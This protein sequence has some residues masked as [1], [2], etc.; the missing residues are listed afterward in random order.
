MRA[1]QLVT[2]ILLAGMELCKAPGIGNCAGTVAFAESLRSEGSSEV[3]SLSSARAEQCLELI[4][5]DGLD[6]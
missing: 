1:I 4:V 3:W 5:T 6:G 2:L